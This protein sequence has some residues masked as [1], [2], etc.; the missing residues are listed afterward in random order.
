M[1]NK[2]LWGGRFNEPLDRDA[3]TLSYSLESD[4]RLV[5]YDL[6]VNQAHITALHAGGWL[7][8][9][10]FQTLYDCL[11]QLKIDFKDHPEKCYKNDASNVS[12]QNVV[13]T[14]ERKCT[15]E[16]LEM[17]KLLLIQDCIPKM[18]LNVYKQ[19]FKHS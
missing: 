9:N 6:L 4:K 15:P 16:N 12:L 5:Q 13:V 11:E 7:L 3:I 1:T 14:W 19:S 2:K 10:E 17:I 8:D 18:L